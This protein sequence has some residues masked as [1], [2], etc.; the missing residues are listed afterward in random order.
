VRRPG[1]TNDAGNVNGQAAL[2]TPAWRREPYRMFFPLGLILAWA[3]ILH[4]LLH[5]AGFLPNY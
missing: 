4:W 2:S 1:R 5:A 3:G